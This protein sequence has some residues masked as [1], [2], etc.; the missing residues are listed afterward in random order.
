MSTI[1][2]TVLDKI[3]DYIKSF[4]YKKSEHGNWK[5]MYDAAIFSYQLAREEL[6]KE[7]ERLMGMLDKAIEAGVNFESSLKEKENR[8][9]ELEKGMEGKCYQ[10]V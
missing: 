5:T 3:E 6:E 10:P 9:A 2:K 8:I 7:V 1:P 4:G